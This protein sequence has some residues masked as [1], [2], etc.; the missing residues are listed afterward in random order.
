MTTRSRNQRNLLLALLLMFLLSGS[1]QAPPEPPPN[2][3][4][5]GENGHEPG[6]HDIPSS[7]IASQVALRAD[8]GRNTY[9][10]I[11]GAFTRNSNCSSSVM[12]NSCSIIEAPDTH[13]FS[14]SNRHWRT[15]RG[16][17]PQGQDYF[18]SFIHPS[19]VNGANGDRTGRNRNEIKGQGGKSPTT[20]LF[21]SGDRVG[22]HWYFR[23][24]SNYNQPSGG[25]GCYL[26][27]LHSIERG[28]IIKVLIRGG[29]RLDVTHDP[30]NVNVNERSLGSIDF[31]S[32]RGAWLEAAEYLE[33]RDNG[34]YEISIWRADT[35]QRVYHEREPN[36]DMLAGTIRPKWGT[37]RPRG[38]SGYNSEDTVD[39]ADFHIA[40]LS[41]LPEIIA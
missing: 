22:L 15:I 27:Q 41:A 36:I 11:N 6:A 14:G 19:D 8:A 5:D 40:Q 35:G 25:D 26:H 16:G 17:G 34:F 30:N 23:V 9:V 12:E 29:N 28:P 4:P 20:M 7:L 3:E 21:A 24:G 31:A 39:F 10:Q 18:R 13:S 32:H 1:R 38:L 37:Y 33:C 2:G